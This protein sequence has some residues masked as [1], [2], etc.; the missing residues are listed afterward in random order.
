MQMMALFVGGFLSLGLVLFSC[1]DFNYISK[2]FYPMK[3]KPAIYLPYYII[4]K[5][6][7][8]LRRLLGKTP[9]TLKKK[10]KTREREVCLSVLA[11]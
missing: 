8:E 5:I 4:L 7:M 9:L 3:T 6:C 11:V 1:V 2:I 10:K